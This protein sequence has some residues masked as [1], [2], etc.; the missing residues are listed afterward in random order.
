MPIK[1]INIM[2]FYNVSVVVSLVMP[3]YA[4]AKVPLYIR[5]GFRFENVVNLM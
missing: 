1:D 5:D 3:V 4:T 2:V